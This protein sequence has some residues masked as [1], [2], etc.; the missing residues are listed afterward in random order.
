MLKTMTVRTTI[1]AIL[2][3]LSMSAHAIADAAARPI[4]IPAG[5]LITAL[6]SL[7]KQAD[8]ELVYQADQLKGIHTGGVSGTYEPK[9]AV[10]LLLK[11]TQLTIRTDETTGVMLV[12]PPRA[13][14]ALSLKAPSGTGAGSTAGPSERS[15]SFWSR[16]RLAQS[17]TRSTSQADTTNSSPSRGEGQGEGEKPAQ[18]QKVIEL[19]EIVVTGTHIRGAQSVSPVI[20]ID[21]QQ[22]ARSGYT[23]VGD[24]IRSLPQNFGGGNNPALS[25]GNAP[26]PEN[27]N[28]SGGSSPNLRGLGPGSTLTL[29]N[30]HRLGQDGGLGAVD[31]TLIPLAAIDRIEVVTDSSSAAYGSDAVAGVVNFVMKDHYA[32]A[33]TGLSFGEATQGGGT[34]L[35]FSQLLGGVWASG[36]ALLAYERSRQDPVD[37]TDRSYTA[38]VSS[39]SW[40]LPKT[41]RDSLFLAANQQLSERISASID[42]LYTSRESRREFTY[43][44]FVPFPSINAPNSVRQFATNAALN[45]SLD[46]DWEVTASASAAEE[47]NHSRALLFTPGVAGQTPFIA[48]RL[49]GTTRSFE[50]K[51]DGP[52]GSLPAGPLRLALGGGYR[53]EKFDEIALLEGSSAS[54]GKRHIEYAFGELNAPLI[55]SPARG[56]LDLTVSGR[57]EQYSDV[58]GKFVPKTGLLYRPSETLTLRTSWSEAFRAPTLT[59]LNKVETI[60]IDPVADPQSGTGTSLILF[61]TGGNQDLDPESA[62][63]WSAGFDFAPSWTPGVQ[64]SATYFSI[65][66]KNRVL[67]LDGDA[68]A[69]TDAANA[70]FVSRS[71]SAELQQSLIAGAAGGLQNNSGL[72]YDPS[73]IAAIVDGRSLNISQ[74][75]LDG[76]DILL[77]YDRAVAIGQLSLYANATFLRIEQQPTNVS[78]ETELTGR[79]FSPPRRRAR[80]GATWS[81][82]PW[83]STAAINWTSSSRNVYQPDQA[84]VSAWTVV[85]FQ[86]SYR[87]EFARMLRGLHASVSVQNVFDEDPPLLSVGD[88]VFLGYNYDSLNTTPLGRYYTIQVTKRWGSGTDAGP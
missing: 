28:F 18:R 56:S 44:D 45:A 83:S 52:L 31:I 24:V 15:K 63:S 81:T 6:E 79:A 13:S 66:Y 38:E 64:L 17:D 88:G 4:N 35:R 9:E 68:T 72:P 77:N 41:K 8:I 1:A 12:T 19:E 2:A 7:A 58:G 43:P 85:D 71:P 25:V 34:E 5:D 11:G 49:I 59:A 86:L 73:T 57:Y 70:P 20:K 14:Q 27:S 22:I 76:V 29:V 36:N 50:L 48:Q 47:R 84:K 67:S 46:R 30:G 23:A 62:S 80:A 61:R 21:S 10:S 3:G 82:G 87:P 33:E 60:A 16:L 37:S 65:N 51:G 26:T 32:G 54:D 55:A 75:K 40:L 78:P 53:H 69:L 39:P 74:Q 42:G